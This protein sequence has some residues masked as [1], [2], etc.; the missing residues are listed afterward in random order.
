VL[1]LQGGGYVEVG[2]FQGDDRILSPVFPELN[3]TA[4]RILSAG[5]KSE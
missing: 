5:K 3:L 4:E 2:I 1:E